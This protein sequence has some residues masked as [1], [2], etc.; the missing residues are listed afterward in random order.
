MVVSFIS[1]FWLVCLLLVLNVAEADPPAQMPL[2]DDILGSFPHAIINIEL[3]KNELAR[4]YSF[5]FVLQAL[6]HTNQTRTCEM[7]SLH[8]RT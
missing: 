5:S 3:K 1:D 7:D 6:K 8:S 4:R 2:L